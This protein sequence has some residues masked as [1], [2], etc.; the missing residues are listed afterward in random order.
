MSQTPYDSVPAK[1]FW[2]QAVAEKSL[3]DIDLDWEPRF[4]IGQQTRIATFGSCFAQHFGKALKRRGMAWLDCEPVNPGL[5]DALCHRFGYRSFS[6]RTGNIYTASLLRQWTRWAVGRD[7]PPDEV[8][9]QDG[10]FF[11]PFRPRIEPGGFETAQEVQDMRAVTLTA[12]QQAIRQAQVFVFTL[13]L[14]ESWFHSDGHEYP[15][16]P[17][18]AAGRFDPE[19]HQFRNQRFEETRTALVQA[20]HLMRRENPQIRFL[21]TVSPVPLTA[22]NSGQHV[23]VATM[24]SKSILRAVAGD[25][26]ESL[27][28][29]DYFPSYEIINS[30]AFRAVFFDPNMRSVNPRGV[31]FVM[32]TFFRALEQKH[33]LPPALGA[34]PTADDIACEEALLASFGEGA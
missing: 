8:W 16:C 12:F 22:T 6:A 24:D 26:A 9:E 33:G 34:L 27:K 2:K 20:I 28:G 11:D 25:V 29:V 31:D 10:R 32:E 18:T 13:G 4:R 30:P 15:M 7:A 17:G 21:L 5:S 14:T 23:V 3:F 19:R 1:G